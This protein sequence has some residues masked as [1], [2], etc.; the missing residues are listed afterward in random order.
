MWELFAKC[1][2]TT[3]ATATAANAEA[4]GV[5]RRQQRVIINYL[6]GSQPVIW[7]HLIDQHAARVCEFGMDDGSALSQPFEHSE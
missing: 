3:T 2:I 4:A 7:S 5:S 6:F 1:Q